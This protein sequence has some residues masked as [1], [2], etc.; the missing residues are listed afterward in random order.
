MRVG[1]RWDAEC[2]AGCDARALRVR[3]PC[4]ARALR[5]LCGKARA[6]LE[7]L[8][9]MMPV[10]MEKMTMPMTIHRVARILP[11]GVTGTL[12]PYPTGRSRVRDRRD[13][14][15][16]EMRKALEVP[17][18]HASLIMKRRTQEQDMG[19]GR[20]R[21]PASVSRGHVRTCG[22][23][24]D[25]KPQGVVDALG[26][27]S[28]EVVCIGTS[29]AQPKSMR[30]DDDQDEQ[31]AAK[32]HKERLRERLN[33]RLKERDAT[34]V[35]DDGHAVIEVGGQVVDAASPRCPVGRTVAG[36]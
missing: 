14:G 31:E 24:D 9:D 12:S 7:K 36:L 32:V 23:G 28:R 3:S 17:Y 29:F 1:R 33:Q 18:R 34:R 27:P 11:S 10:R 13:T 5:V 35:V 15:W 19:T 30:K 22:D 21:N 20:P 16:V 4:A 26:P 6:L 2:D 8:L 25:R